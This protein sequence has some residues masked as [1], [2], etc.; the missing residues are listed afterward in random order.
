M[1]AGLYLTLKHIVLALGPEISRLP[2]KW[3]TWIF[4]S[5]DALSIVIQAVGGGISAAAS[6][7]DTLDVG[8]K[9]MI[10]GIGIQVAT[11]AVCVVLASDFA[12]SLFRSGLYRKTGSGWERISAYV[13]S[14]KGFYWYLTSFAAAFLFIF[15]RCIYRLPEMVGGWGN[16]LMRDE[17]EFLILDGG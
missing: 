15:I 2:A 14:R 12:F 1:A 8:N 9:L 16:P 7:A 13:N 4:I 6:D 11:M 17:T 5:C 10:A 3:Y